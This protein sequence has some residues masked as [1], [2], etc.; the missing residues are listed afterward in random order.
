M[1]GSTNQ[2]LTSREAQKK[3]E[4]GLVGIFLCD[5]NNKKREK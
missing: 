5:N 2:Q 1:V 3:S 4:V